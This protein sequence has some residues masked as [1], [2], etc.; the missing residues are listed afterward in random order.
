MSQKALK[1]VL[2]YKKHKFDTLNLFTRHEELLLNPS[3]SFEFC[4]AYL[5]EIDASCLLLNKTFS[6]IKEKD[7]ELVI[8]KIPSIKTQNNQSVIESI[9]E[10]ASL[11]FPKLLVI[12]SDF[13]FKHKL[14]E[15]IHYDSP[16]FKLKKASHVIKEINLFNIPAKHICFP[17]DYINHVPPSPHYQKNHPTWNLNSDDTKYQFGGI[18]EKHESNPLFHLISFTTIPKNIKAK[19]LNKLILASHLRELEEHLEPIFYQ[20]DKNGYPYRI[21]NI[22]ETSDVIPNPL[23]ETYVTLANT[24]NRWYHQS[25]GASNDR[26]NLFKIGSPTW[27]QEE[28]LLNC[29]ICNEEMEFIMQLDSGLPDDENNKIYYGGGGI[30]YIF[31]CAKTQ[32]SGYL[33]QFT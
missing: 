22:Q 28:E 24:P 4:I 20:H 29:P 7:F 13:I 14:E 30:C 21:G 15:Y 3:D 19:S 8:K 6:F 11:Q 27:I 31:W 25:W 2:E 1:L 26:E 32:V 23:K 9:I 18:L 5:N 17:N 33:L 12:N 16:L 10:Y